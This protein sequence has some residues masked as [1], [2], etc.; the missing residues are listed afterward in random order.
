MSE[1]KFTTNSASSSGKS[2]DKKY[3]KYV[4]IGSSGTRTYRSV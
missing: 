4:G 3:G 1:I 2:G